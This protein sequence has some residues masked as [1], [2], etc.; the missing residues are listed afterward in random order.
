MTRL[1]LPYSLSTGIEAG[2]AEV[3]GYLRS[4]R[5]QGFCVVDHTIPP[6]ELRR[7][8]DSVLASQSRVR[9]QHLR[10][11]TEF[12]DAHGIEHEKGSMTHGNS[13]RPS[14]GQVVWEPDAARPPKPP[15]CLNQIAENMVFAQHVAEPRVLAVARA[16]LDPHVRIAQTEMYKAAPAAQESARPDG[17][18]YRSWHTDW[19]HDLSAYLHSDLSG[20]SQE[21]WRNAGAVA[22]PFPDVTMALSTIWYLGPEDVSPHNGA[23]WIVPYSHKD[24]RNPRGPA[25]GIDERSPIPGELQIRCPAGST[26][27]QDS[28]TWHTNGLNYSEAP[29]HAAV[30][31]YAPWWLSVNEFGGGIPTSQCNTYVPRSAFERLPVA[32]QEL[33]RHCVRGEQLYNSGRLG[34]EDYIQ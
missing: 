7:V 9:E 20:F 29:R 11:A 25:D 22:Q 2:E 32:V 16:M 6:A 30:L 21:P 26:F 12:F 27:I 13:G 4:L 18:E 3:P 31:R 14:S 23:T 10:E 34:A 19:P 33:Y 15:P 1:L 17:Q 28:R 24:P 8:R 5:E